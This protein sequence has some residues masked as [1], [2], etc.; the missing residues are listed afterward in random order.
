[1]PFVSTLI[2]PPSSLGFSG[3]P[4]TVPQ[5]LSCVDS[6]WKRPN[7]ISPFDANGSLARKIA[8]LTLYR[9]LM[10]LILLP[11]TQLSCRFCLPRSAKGL[12][13]FHPAGQRLCRLHA[14]ERFSAVIPHSIHDS[15]QSLRQTLPLPFAE[16]V[17]RD[18]GIPDR[19][20]LRPSPRLQPAGSQASSPVHDFQT[21]VRT[22]FIPRR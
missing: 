5:W 8:W 21:H 12:R 17:A 16:P 9:G 15:G 11:T 6:F 19:I 13:R 3:V 22:T 7:L 10:N 2:A 14:V 20:R 1:M 18:R 4:S